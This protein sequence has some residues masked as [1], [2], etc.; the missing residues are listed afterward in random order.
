MCWTAKGADPL[1]FGALEV[2][3]GEA[4]PTVRR[5]IQARG[6]PPPRSSYLDLPRLLEQADPVRWR[7]SGRHS[8]VL[9]ALRFLDF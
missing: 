2:A 3:V 4:L 1:R 8:P 5:I 9:N 6:E 7:A